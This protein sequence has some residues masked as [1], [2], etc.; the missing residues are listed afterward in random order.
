[1]TRSELISV[2]A[3]RQPHFSPRDVELAV[4]CM[5]ELMVQTLEAAGRIEIRGFGCFAIHHREPRLGRNPK[6]GEPVSLLAKSAVHFKPGKAL[7][8]RVNASREKYGIMSF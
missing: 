5:L 6:T 3:Q 2:L 7:R 4:H 8:D 1:M